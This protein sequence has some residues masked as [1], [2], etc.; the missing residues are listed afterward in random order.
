MIHGIEWR[1][2]IATGL[3]IG[4]A[5]SNAVEVI[6]AWEVAIACLVFVSVVV[7]EREG[8]TPTAAVLLALAA[9]VAGLV[10]GGA[11]TQAIEAG[12]LTGREGSTVNLV[13]FVTA[14][15]RKST[16]GWRLLLET[17]AGR[18]AAEASGIPPGVSTGDRVAVSGE[19]DEVPEWLADY[20]EV[21]GIS[22]VIGAESIERVPGNREGLAGLID[23]VRD[24]AE[25][26]LGFGIG[27]PEAAL[28]RGFVLGQDQMIG[29]TVI[30]DFRGSGLAHLLAVSGQNILLLAI[31]A[32][33][34]LAALGLPLKVRLTVLIALIALYVPVTG[35]GP[36]IQRAGIMGVAAIAAT[37]AARPVM[38]SWILAFAAALTLGLNP[39][40]LFDPGWQLSFAAVAGIMVF[41]RPI[42]GS[43]TT[44][45]PGRESRFMTAVADGVAVTAA[46]SFATLPLIVLH[47]EAVPVATLG[48]NLVAM[49][50]V[51]PS[52]W[53]GMSA[54]AL[55]QIEPALAFPLNQAN[56]VLLAFIARVA[57]EMGGEGAAVAIPGSGPVVI[58][59]ATA[60]IWVFV[61]V[62]I[63][64]PRTLAVFLVAATVI[65]ALIL[66]QGGRRDLAPPPPGGMRIE[67][68]DV[69]QGDAFLVRSSSGRSVLVDAGPP[70]GGVGDAIESAGIERLDAVILTHLD[71]DHIG[72]LADVLGRFEVNAVLFEEQDRAI[73]AAIAGE[74][75]TGRRLAAGDVL[76]LG[77]G[78]MTILSPQAGVDP[79]TD[80]NDRSLVVLVEALGYRALLT[81]DAES[82]SVSIRPGPV[83]ILKLAHHGSRD[84]GL[85]GLLAATQP[86]IGL[87]SAGR[88]NRYGHPD[89]STLESLGN[90]GVR[91]YRTDRDGT[92]SLVISTSGIAV[93]KGR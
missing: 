92:V 74:R 66:V 52:M 67:M 23:G 36:S 16:D 17:A 87:I 31:L 55:G 8:L 6:A 21:Q 76:G 61:S 9:T 4:I 56:A 39:R 3:A 64:F 46:A 51:A 19:V 22:T 53:L 60:A 35:A 80:R 25:E 79:S 69:G 45:L 28:A 10:I 59:L 14:P 44:V 38:R 81:G 48:A 24:R 49:P 29:P 86:R 12:A 72:G 41:A 7:I 54:A 26:A 15:P 42:A 5:L 83:D 90:A 84:E 1:L 65:P 11:R 63:R 34:L 70:G 30:E 68:L 85:D 71:L 88:E 57:S 77:S 27:R 78:R 58:L 40:A 91:S 2:V 93:E 75:A 50:A 89:A 73:R 13:G 82:E 18:V 32:T 33:P 47:F 62:L 37:A 43:L 20:L